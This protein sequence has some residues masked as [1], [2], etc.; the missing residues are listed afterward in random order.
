[1]T[2]ARRWAL[3]GVGVLLLVTTPFLVRALPAHDDGTSA[4]VL[5]Q[6]VQGSRDVA[7]SGYVESGGVGRRCRPTTS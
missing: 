2:A 1:M 7:F 3:V 5:L 6:R 4:V